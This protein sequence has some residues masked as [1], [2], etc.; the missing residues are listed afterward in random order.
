MEAFKYAGKTSAGI[1][2]KGVIQAAS[3]DEAMSILRQQGIRATSVKPKPK[4]IEIKIPGLGRGVK[5]TE[6]V[7][8]TRQ[9]ATMID[10]GLPLVQCLDILSSQ[11]E[12]KTFAKAIAAVKQDVE[13][14]STYADA[15]RK[16]PNIFNDLYVNM[17]EAGEVGGI[18]DTILNRLA[19]YIEK[20]VKL[21]KK[22]KGA[23][24]YPA[25][26]LSVAVIVVAIIMVYVIPVF[27]KMFAGFGSALPAPTRLVIAMSVFVKANIVFMIMAIVLFVIAFSQAYK[28]SQR[29]KKGVHIALLRFPLIGTLIRKVAVA[30]FTRTLGTLISSGVPILD[31]LEIVAKTANNKVIEEA[32]MKTR[33]SIRE[34][35][36]IAEP[37]SETKVFPPM[38]VQMIGVG[39]QTG[40]LDAMLS[41]IADFYDEEVDNAVATLTSMLEPIMMVFLGGTVGFLVVAMYLPVF[42]MAE[43]VH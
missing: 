7:I 17:V 6:I 12:N 26:V 5:E 38:V 27:Q 29:F 33:E 11:T 9:F 42:K 21:K 41:K 2:K 35:K 32:V 13:G 34:G 37:L 1:I 14:G 28:R 23:M 24:V 3:K 40:A 43:V 8:F 16:H 19:G 31:G 10:A 39:E 22:V 4:D 18:L 25:V 15:L 20:A 36:T 30:K